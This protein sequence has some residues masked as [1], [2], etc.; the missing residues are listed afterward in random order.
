MAHSGPRRRGGR[1]RGE[2]SDENELNAP[3]LLHSGVWEL[4]ELG[5]QR[6]T[7]RTPGVFVA[8]RSWSLK[9]SVA[10][11]DVAF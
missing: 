6:V 1:W 10:G 8:E 2:V 9:H 5:A 11:T 4:V 3:R 7:V